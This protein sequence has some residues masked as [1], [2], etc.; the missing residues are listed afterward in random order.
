MNFVKNPS[1]KSKPSHAASQKYSQLLFTIRIIEIKINI[2]I[3][4]YFYSKINKIQ[5]TLQV[6]YILTSEFNI[7]CTIYKDLINIIE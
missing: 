1:Y 5:T 2:Y 3:F 6:K 7:H 4:F